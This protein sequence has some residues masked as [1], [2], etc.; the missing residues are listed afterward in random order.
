MPHRFL[1]MFTLALAACPMAIAS[2]AET[3]AARP[4]EII[5]VPAGR[6]LIDAPLMF[7]VDGGLYGPGTIVQTDPTQPI[8]RVDHAAGVRIEGVTL[9]R[10]EGARKS[11]ESAIRADHAR[12]LLIR[13]DTNEVVQI[14]APELVALCERICAEHGLELQGRRF[15]IFAAAP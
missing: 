5:E 13:V 14:D 9:T 11:S 2:L 3:I 7:T 12:D 8:V 4:G 6:H 10:P 15:Q 1:F